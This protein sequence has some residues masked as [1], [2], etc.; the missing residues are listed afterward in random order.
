M[1]RD[2]VVPGQD[3]DDRLRGRERVI[4]HF[5]YVAALKVGAMPNFGEVENRGT[6]SSEHLSYSGR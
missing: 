2:F 6:A 1:N 4:Q 5:A 3:D